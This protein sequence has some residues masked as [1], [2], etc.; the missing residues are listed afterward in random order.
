MAPIGSP[1]LTSYDDRMLEH[2]SA[3]TNPGMADI[4]DL[5]SMH[6][7]SKCRH[8]LAGSG[9]KED[10][11][12]G[13]FEKLMRGRK[14]PSLARSARGNVPVGSGFPTLGMAEGPTSIQR[15]QWPRLAPP[16]A[17]DDDS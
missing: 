6:T 1:F 12:C 10:G 9:K 7:C 3:E 8:W 14:A 4:V 16:A 2:T 17:Q 15:R 5:D 13:L 11:C